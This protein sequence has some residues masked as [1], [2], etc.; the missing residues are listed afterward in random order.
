M[1]IA[2][3]I[4]KL[5]FGAFLLTLLCVVT[6]VVTINVVENAGRLANLPSA[7]SSTALLQL[8]LFS[9][10]NYTYQMIPIALFLSL[11]IAAT[12]L[13]QRGEMLAVY[14]NGIG[15][16]RILAGF[17][18]VMIT[19]TV[20]AL[21][22]GEFISPSSHRALEQLQ[23]RG[24]K[25]HDKD[26][27]RFYAHRNHWY[28]QGSTML[29][30]PEVDMAQGV[31]HHPVIYHIQAGKLESITTAQRM[32]HERNGWYLYD[33]RVISTTNPVIT[34]HPTVQIALTVQPSDLIAVTG[35]PRQ[36]SMPHLTTLISRRRNAGFDTGAHLVEL[37]QRWAHPLLCV[38]FF[39]IAAP[40][41]VQPRRHAS[42]AATLGAGVSVMAVIYGAET[43]FRMLALGHKL[44]LG[45]GAWG[46]AVLC[47]ICFPIS[48]ILSRRHANQ[49]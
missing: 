5:C 49:K 48:V 11:L 27:S 8:V 23:D 17:I 22:W 34:T 37:H 10:G 3:Y 47:L 18:I 45:L 32:V 35:D 14:T 29:Y 21:V 31:F 9:S 2:A 40:W 16:N 4:A 42:L 1:R 26:I 12:I 28:H 15:P 46:G 20:L 25:T 24:L 38:W 30:L 19:T 41:I 43:F 36:L 6:F 13:A 33:A 7:D 39:L 44:P